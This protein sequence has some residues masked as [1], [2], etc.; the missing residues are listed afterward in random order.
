[1]TNILLDTNELQESIDEINRLSLT[2][3]VPKKNIQ[4]INNVIL[5]MMN[6]FV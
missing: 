2:F 6:L 4:N 1:M 5:L 3:Q